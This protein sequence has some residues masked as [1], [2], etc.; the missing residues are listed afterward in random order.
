MLGALVKPRERRSPQWRRV[1]R[2]H[3][4][5]HPSCAACGTRTRVEVH[6]IVPVHVAPDRELDSGNLL[7][8]CRGRLHRGCHFRVG[9]LRNWRRWNPNVV[10]DA[11]AS[12]ANLRR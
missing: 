6:H 8:L 5:A 11:A 3:L 1:E 10:A 12:L 7:S 2:I 9:H 4:L